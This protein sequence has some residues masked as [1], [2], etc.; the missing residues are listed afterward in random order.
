MAATGQGIASGRGA[1]SGHR[2]IEEM[3]KNW[4]LIGLLLIVTFVSGVLPCYLSDYLGG[5]RCV[6][7]SWAFSI[8]SAYVGYYA[9]TRILRQVKAF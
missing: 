5:W 3:S 9:L 8:I 2:T 1:L 6:A 7:V 4:P